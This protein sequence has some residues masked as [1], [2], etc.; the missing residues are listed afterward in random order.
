MKKANLIIVADRNPRIRGFLR[1][2][3]AD[4]GYHVQLVENGKELLNLIDS[5]LHIDLIVL[6]PDFPGMDPIEMAQK[7]GDRI[8]QLPVVLF[9]FRESEEL[10]A[11]V[12]GTVFHVEKNGQSIDILKE[13]IQSILS[14][15]ESIARFS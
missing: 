13:T 6:D 2:E 4:N 10:S 8:P 1:R 12:N 14:G 11:F 7:I 3:L 5:R 9:C 15:A